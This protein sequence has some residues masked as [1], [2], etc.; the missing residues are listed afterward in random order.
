MQVLNSRN[1]VTEL[2]PNEEVIVN[3]IQTLLDEGTEMIYGEDM[4]YHTSLDN[5]TARGVLASLVKKEV[6]DVNKKDGG[7]IS[8]FWDEIK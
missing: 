6:I 1:Q 4:E 8:K 5:K 2:T 3:A 7:L